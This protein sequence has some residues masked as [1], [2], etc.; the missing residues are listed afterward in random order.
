VSSRAAATALSGAGEIK[1][2]LT[3]NR[4]P[5]RDIACIAM[6]KTACDWATA[7]PNPGWIED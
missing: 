5:G 3:L 2:G 6:R 7:S 4:C 1:P